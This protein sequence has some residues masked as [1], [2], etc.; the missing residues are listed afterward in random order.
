MKTKRTPL[1]SSPAKGE[2]GFEKARGDEYFGDESQEGISNF[3]KFT[4][5]LLQLLEGRSPGR[6]AHVHVEQF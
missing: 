3:A 5:L 2:G 6:K 1:R 4:R